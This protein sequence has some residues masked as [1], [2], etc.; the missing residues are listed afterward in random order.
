MELGTH[1]KQNRQLKGISQEDLAQTIFVSRQTVSNWETGK[2]YPDVQSL[3]LLSNLFDVSV[4]SLIKGDLD[5][6]EKIINEDAR[7][8]MALGWVILVGVVL[9]VAMFALG[10]G[11][12]GWGIAPSLVIF[13]LLW[14]IALAAAIATE[15][16]KKKHDIETYSEIVAFQKGETVDRTK[17]SS[18]WVRRHPI[19]STALYALAGATVGAAIGVGIAM[20]MG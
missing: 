9:S 6:M 2:T 18:R 15:H 7:K 1:I 8:I 19:A 20:F 13:F 4:D 12:W 16:L 17:R 10:H 14:G 5:T 3:L 11:V